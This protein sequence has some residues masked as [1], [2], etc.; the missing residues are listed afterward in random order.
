MLE[1]NNKNDGKNI[2]VNVKQNCNRSYD[3]PLN[4]LVTQVPQHKELQT[5]NFNPYSPRHNIYY[6]SEIAR[7]YKEAKSLA[8]E[9]ILSSMRILRV[10]EN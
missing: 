3:N 4:N 6:V 1:F 10:L 5:F 7:A 9:H 8:R 2:N